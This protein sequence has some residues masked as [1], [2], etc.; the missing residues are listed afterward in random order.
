MK[1]AL[2]VAASSPLFGQ[3]SGPAASAPPARPGAYLLL[4]NLSTSLETQIGRWRQV[5]FDPGLYCYAG[6]ALGPGGLA[7]RLRRYASGA[8]RPH[9]HIDYLLPHAELLGALAREDPQR[10]ECAWA[11]WVSSRAQATIRGFGSSDCACSGHLFLLGPATG[12]AAFIEL[13]QRE[14][15]ARWFPAPCTLTQRPPPDSRHR[16][17]QDWP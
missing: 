9:W 14:L 10:L 5:A 3:G 11:A 7:A 15:A 8:G 6:S 2:P 4:L 1:P 17:T 13:A 12:A 16:E